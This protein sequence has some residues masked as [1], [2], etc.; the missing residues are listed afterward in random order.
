M[1]KKQR[2]LLSLLTAAFLASLGLFCWLLQVEAGVLGGYEKTAVLICTAE[3]PKGQVL[4]AQNASAYLA[5][6]EV[7]ADLVSS[8]MLQSLSQVCDLAAVCTIQEG[9]LVSGAM[10]ESLSEILEQMQEPVIAGCKAEDLY[11]VVGGVLRAGDRVHIYAVLSSGETFVWENV[12]VQEVFDSS[13]NSIP[14]SDTKTAAQRINIYLE[15]EAVAAF[16]EAL[17]GGSLRMVKVCT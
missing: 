16:Y 1:K 2:I 12:Y 17:S 13:G 15:K 10:F 11:Q 5:V 14:A 7:D 6:A 4:T 3:I 8:A 9:V